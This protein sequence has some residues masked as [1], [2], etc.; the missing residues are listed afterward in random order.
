METAEVIRNS[1]CKGEWVVSVDLT[2][3]YFHIPIHHKYNKY[4]SLFLC[5]LSFPRFRLFSTSFYCVSK[6]LLTK[7]IKTSQDLA[8]VG[9]FAS[10]LTHI[11]TALTV[12]NLA[13]VM[14]PVSLL[15][16]RVKYVLLSQ[17]NKR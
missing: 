9:T 1:I 3:A 12:G 15:K 8:N 13:R 16:V 6:C 17:K 5:V 4:F 7:R 10:H 11:I 2:D 14:T